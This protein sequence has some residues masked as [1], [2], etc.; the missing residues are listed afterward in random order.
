MLYYSMNEVTTN[1]ISD[2]ID[3]SNDVVK[4]GNIYPTLAECFQF[5]LKNNI[6]I[7][8]LFLLLFV[9][10]VIFHSNGN[11]IIHQILNTKTEKEMSF[12]QKTLSFIIL[13][14]IIIMIELIA[15]T[16]VSVLIFCIRK[17]SYVN[18]FFTLTEDNSITY[19][20]AL[21]VELLSFGLTSILII[22]FI[23]PITSPRSLL[24]QLAAAF[25]FSLIVLGL[26]IISPFL[27]KLK[28]QYNLLGI[29][30]F[31]VKKN[32]DTVSNEENNT[33]K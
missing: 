22:F 26:S 27:L 28:I 25:L 2:V 32:K 16:V 31:F 21:M 1:S 15:I 9:F 14:F 20:N 33:T 6:I 13:I 24:D 18:D 10:V 23:I 8:L 30:E 11:N 17:L 29:K 7:L 4:P 3:N 5:V 19:W 12:L